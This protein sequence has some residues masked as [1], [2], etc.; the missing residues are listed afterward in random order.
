MKK[1]KNTRPQK[2]LILISLL[3]AMQPKYF[4][5]FFII[6][7]ASFSA[8]CTK[9]TTIHSQDQ[10]SSPVIDAHDPA[11]AKS[12]EAAPQQLLGGDRDAHGC[13]GSAGYSWCESTNRC[14]RPWEEK[15]PETAPPPTE[16]SAVRIRSNIYGFSDTPD[17]Y[18]FENADYTGFDLLQALQDEGPGQSVQKQPV[19]YT[20]DNVKKLNQ[21]ITSELAKKEEKFRAVSA[22]HLASGLDVVSGVIWPMDRTWDEP[23]YKTEEAAYRAYLNQLRDASRVLIVDQSKVAVV[24]GLPLHGPTVTGGDVESCRAEK[25][26][27]NITWKCFTGMDLDET[28]NQLGDPHYTTW[29]LSRDGRVLKKTDTVEP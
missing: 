27:S 10:A 28:T 13:I 20:P 22:C 8:G 3:D 14:Q 12:F 7:L 24:Q 4:V 16:H 25:S 1:P 2:K 21:S 11:T 6:S 15:C 23:D 17:C 29:T 18:F 26:D 5:V 9:Q 19:F